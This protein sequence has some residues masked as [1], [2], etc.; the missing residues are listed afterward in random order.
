MAPASTDWARVFTVSVDRADAPALAGVY[1][2]T[3]AATH[4]PAVAGTNTPVVAST[5]APANGAHPPAAAT[6]ATATSGSLCFTPRYRLQAGL[7]Y[8]VRYALGADKADQVLRPPAAPRSAAAR[9]ERLQPSAA[10]WPENQ[11]RFYLHFSQPMARGEAFARLHLIEVT[12][13]NTNASAEVKLP[14]LEIHEELWDREQRRL[15]VLFDPGRVKR[16]LVPHNDVGPPLVAGRRYRLVVDAAWPDAAGQPMAA[17]FEKE[18]IATAAVR[19]GVAPAEWRVTPPRAGTRQPVVVDFPRPLDSGLLV[20][21][22]S[23]LGVAGESHTE[24]EEMRW[25]FVPDQPWTA[26]Q[27][28]IEVGSALEDVAGNRLGRAFDV[29]LDVFDRVKTAPA[30]SHRL[31]FTPAR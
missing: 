5:N 3:L 23:V 22:F 2:R 10:Q 30:A 17:P 4:A 12:N 8:R 21:C 19:Q 18:F 1:S 11:L 14:F 25:L 27:Q 16:G 15:T 13:A 29:D 7:A 24:R 6:R 28:S 9:V 31:P 20:S 26:G